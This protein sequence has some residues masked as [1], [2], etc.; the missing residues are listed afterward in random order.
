MIL[1]LAHK[2]LGH[3]GL[4]LEVPMEHASHHRDVPELMG[5]APDVDKG[6]GERV[7]RKSRQIKNQT[8]R[9]NAVGCDKGVE[10]ILNHIIGQATLEKDPVAKGDGAVQSKGQVDLQ[11]DLDPISKDDAVQEGR[12]GEEEHRDQEVEVAPRLK[13]ITGY[14]RMHFPTLWYLTGKQPKVSQ[15][16][17]M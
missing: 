12:G 2:L 13:E 6:G 9:E 14:Y 10:T 8:H 1:V 15:M 5:V 16:R 11:V 4:K 7:L 3:H 17:G